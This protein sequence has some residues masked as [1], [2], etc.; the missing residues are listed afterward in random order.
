MSKQF[1]IYSYR[2]VKSNLEEDFIGDG[3]CSVDPTAY[4]VDQLLSVLIVGEDLHDSLLLLVNARHYFHDPP[5]VR[6][7]LPLFVDRLQL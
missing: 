1:K 6:T 2:A 4:L 3:K 7:P 5:R